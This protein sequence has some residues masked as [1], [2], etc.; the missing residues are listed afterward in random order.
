MKSDILRTVERT[1]AVQSDLG[2][3]MVKRRAVV[4]TGNGGEYSQTRSSKQGEQPPAAVLR[5]VMYPRV[6][7]PSRAGGPTISCRSRR[8]AVKVT[9]PYQRSVCDHH[10]EQ[11]TLSH[12]EQVAPT[13][14]RSQISQ[15][16]RCAGGFP[17]ATQPPAA[18]A[19]AR[20]AEVGGGG[21]EGDA[22]SAVDGDDVPVVV[23]VKGPMAVVDT[24]LRHV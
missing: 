9:G 21:G 10:I 22:P 5:L 15:V 14:E 6:H 16:G 2:S 12:L 8:P 13:A 23:D 24:L 3:V 19:A 7:H 17:F 18:A 20:L 1:K 11:P 4:A